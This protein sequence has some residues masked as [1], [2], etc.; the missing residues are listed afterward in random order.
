MAL[1]EPPPPTSPSKE[2][3]GETKE[4]RK[5]QEPPS[6][7]SDAANTASAAE[8]REGV[9]EEPTAGKNDQKL[10]ASTDDNAHTG[11]A[12]DDEEDD[13]VVVVDEEEEEEIENGID[14]NTLNVDKEIENAGEDGKEPNLVYVTNPE[15][16]L[17]GKMKGSRSNPGNCRFRVMIQELFWRYDLG[18]KGEKL[19]AVKA[20]I[21]SVEKAGGRF[22]NPYKIVKNS[23]DVAKRNNTNGDNN[24][25]EDNDSVTV[26][27][28]LATSD[29]TEAKI[30]SAFRSAKRSYLAKARAQ[31][32]KKAREME[33]I[34]QSFR[35]AQMSAMK[36]RK[37]QKKSDV[38]VID[39]NYV[40]DYIDDTYVEEGEQRASSAARRTN[41]NPINNGTGNLAPILIQIRDELRQHTVLLRQ[42]KQQTLTGTATATSTANGT[43]TGT[44]TTPAASDSDTFAVTE[45]VGNSPRTTSEAAAIAVRAVLD[46]MAK[47]NAI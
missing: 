22:L 24:E 41:N 36:S 3:D 4:P 11:A 1:K 14:S 34:R 28:Q 26:I 6:K 45:T 19:D 46:E 32:T 12:D 44:D 17:F 25:D 23:S 21:D 13:D 9:A 8:E 20:V 7:G 40:N 10:P 37:R 38:I 42:I 30:S 43:G 16:V 18:S 47:H 31:P 15:D 27:W 2:G 39:D 5:G 33:K 29:D 35:R